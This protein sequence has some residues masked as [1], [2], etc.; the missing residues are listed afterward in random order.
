MQLL[1]LFYL[2]HIYPLQ[3]EIAAYFALVYLATLRILVLIGTTIGVKI[4]LVLFVV[5]TFSLLFFL[6]LFELRYFYIFFWIIIKVLGSCLKANFSR[7]NYWVF[8]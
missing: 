3:I 7:E 4:D 5:E 2:L 8:I 6:N 1:L